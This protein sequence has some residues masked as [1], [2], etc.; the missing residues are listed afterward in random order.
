MKRTLRSAVC[1]AAL[2]AAV[3]ELAF[4]QASN[5]GTVYNGSSYASGTGSQGGSQSGGGPASV[6]VGPVAGATGYYPRKSSCVTAWIERIVHF[7]RYE[8]D[9]IDATGSPGG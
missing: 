7:Q 1:V 3:P 6:A 8:Q 5:G 4:G 2:I 9:I